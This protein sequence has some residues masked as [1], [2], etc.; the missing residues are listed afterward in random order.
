MSAQAGQSSAGAAERHRPRSPRCGFQIEETTGST[1][2]E[3]WLEPGPVDLARAAG[4][5][6]RQRGRVQLERPIQGSGGRAGVGG[7]VRAL[8]QLLGAILTRK[9]ALK[10]CVGM[11]ACWH[12]ISC[13]PS[14]P[15]AQGAS[16]HS[17]SLTRAAPG[18]NKL[19]RRVGRGNEEMRRRTDETA[20]PRSRQG[21]CC[22]PC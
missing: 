1:G 12:C 17:A 3:H 5:G 18:L 9:D 19:R 4:L 10:A 15:A 6:G 20:G 8:L 13:A 7:P 14:A 21:W 2:P 16:E 22:C 11:V